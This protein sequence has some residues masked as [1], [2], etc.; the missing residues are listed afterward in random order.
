MAE[1]KALARHHVDV[2]DRD[3]APVAVEDD[4]DGKADR[5]FRRGDCQHEQREDLAGQ[6]FFFWMSEQVPSGS[7]E[8][9]RGLVE[10]LDAVSLHGC[11]LVVV[12][13]A[14]ERE[15]AREEPASIGIAVAPALRM[16]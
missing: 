3:R 11:E 6:P 10:P 13:G 8:G 2:L 1:Y 7:A 15:S 5:R 9:A 4:E 16:P 12:G 14:E